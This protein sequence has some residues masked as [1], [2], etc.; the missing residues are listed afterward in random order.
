MD[1]L[2]FRQ[3]VLDKNLPGGGEGKLKNA[4]GNA[5]TN[6][7]GNISDSVGTAT[8]TKNNAD[9]PIFFAT[10]GRD[11]Y[12]VSGNTATAQL[13]IPNTKTIP[14]QYRSVNTD[15]V[16]NHT[17][18]INLKL[19]NKNDTVTSVNSQNKSINTQDNITGVI[20]SQFKSIDA[21]DN[22]KS[23]TTSQLKSINAQD[24]SI[25]NS[26]QQLIQ[27]NINDVAK[28][29]K[30]QNKTINGPDTVDKK[31]ITHQPVSINKNDTS[32][33]NSVQAQIKIV[34]RIIE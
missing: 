21:Q 19:A 26:T 33:G 6:R 7:K 20:N 11:T 24:T 9:T 10:E 25:H 23:A 5:G 13:D 30:F 18:I 15:D 12:K 3:Q 27:T 14:V 34:K 16:S 29:I 4:T 1:D 8:A 2:E 17:Q 28:N 31:A 32:V 22:I